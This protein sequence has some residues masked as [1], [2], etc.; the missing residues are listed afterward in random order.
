MLQ[1]GAE[2][3]RSSSHTQT[4]PTIRLRFL[5]F[6]E[7]VAR[8]GKRDRTVYRALDF[9]RKGKQLFYIAFFI[10]L[11]HRWPDICISQDSRRLE[12]A[13]R[14]LKQQRYF[15]EINPVGHGKE[16]SI[17]VWFLL[18]CIV[19][20]SVL[21]DLLDFECILHFYMITHKHATANGRKSCN[22]SLFL[23]NT[24]LLLTY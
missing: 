5:E 1:Y 2:V 12:Y 22:R 15:N 3:P 8:Q 17:H 10:F 7:L 19:E 21:Y 14:I 6:L 20:M 4:N 24:K 16:N 9:K 18:G 23:F 11:S 13:V